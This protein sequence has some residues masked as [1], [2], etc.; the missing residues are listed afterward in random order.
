MRE[1]MVWTTDAV[2]PV[3]GAGDSGDDG[4]DDFRG[5]GMADGTPGG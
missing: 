3:L 4:G 1:L 2:L 5:D